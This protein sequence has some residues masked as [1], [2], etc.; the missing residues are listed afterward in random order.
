[1][2]ADDG[3]APTVALFIDS[4]PTGDPAARIRFQNPSNALDGGLSIYIGLPG[5][6]PGTYTQDTTCGSAALFA[7]LP[8]ADPSTCLTDGGYGCP[9]GCEMTGGPSNPTCTPYATEADYVALASSDCLGNSTAP[10]GSWTATLSSLTSEPDAGTG[11]SGAVIYKVHGT[12]TATLVDQSAAP[13]AAGVSLT[14]S[15]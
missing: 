7:D 14:L 2:P 3:G 13:G 10:A 5:A 4:I 12:L 1:M 8:G 6:S 15:F 9:A 11:T